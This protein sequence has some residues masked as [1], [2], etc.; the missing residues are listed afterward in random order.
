MLLPLLLVISLSFL[1]SHD[2]QLFALPLTLANYRAAINPLYLPILLR[3]LGLA[4]LTTL[5]CFA[6]GYP[7]AYIMTQASHKIK[8]WLLF[9]LIIPF[10]TST[11]IRC[12]ALIAIL[13]AHG[14][15][16]Q[17]LLWLHLIDRPFS[18]LYQTSSVLIG[19]IYTLL[20]F[21]ILPLYASLSKINPQLIEAARDLGAQ[22]L[23]I[24]WR[25]IMPLAKNGIASGILLVWLPA[26]TLFYVPDLLGGAKSLLLGNVISQQFLV[27]LNWP[28]GCAFS[29]LLLLVLLLTALCEKRW[30]Q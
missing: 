26:M 24:H 27:T 13:K 23:K 1:S 16:N 14:L 15:L 28:M 17:L 6:I 25:V 3:S 8:P 10:W 30:L 2:E 20:P 4:T 18:L 21:M 12:Y 29:S 22:R 19:N 11:L 5:A 9:L 7:F